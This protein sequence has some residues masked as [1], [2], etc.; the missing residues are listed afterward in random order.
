MTATRDHLRY[1]DTA[2][3]TERLNMAK[4][5]HLQLFNITQHDHD[6]EDLFIVEYTAACTPSEKVEPYHV[7]VR[8]HMNESRMYS[9]CTCPAGEHAVFCKHAALLAD[10]ITPIGDDIR[11]RVV[12]PDEFLKYTTVALLPEWED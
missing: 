1:P 3:L 2:R 9:H 12:S 6:D 4:A 8:W 5:Q 10:T 7:W 11:M